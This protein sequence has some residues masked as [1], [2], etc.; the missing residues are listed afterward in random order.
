MLFMGKFTVSTWWIFPV[1]YV[2]VY[3]RVAVLRAIPRAQIQI[4]HMYSGDISHRR[5][6]PDDD[7][8]Q[9]SAG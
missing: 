3:Q 4:S 2:N 1:R 7:K 8:S 9:P 6:H 5:S